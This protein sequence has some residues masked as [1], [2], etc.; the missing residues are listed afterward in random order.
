MWTFALRRLAWAIP[1]I[2]LALLLTF[3]LTRIAP[4]DPVLSLLAKSEDTDQLIEITDALYSQTARQM[5]LD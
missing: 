4:G 1:T 3:L 5:G 2:V